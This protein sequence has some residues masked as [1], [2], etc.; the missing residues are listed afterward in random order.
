MQTYSHVLDL[1]MGVV[2]IYGSIMDNLMVRVR[3]SFNQENVFSLG[4]IWK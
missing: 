4:N 3:I 1:S 2:S